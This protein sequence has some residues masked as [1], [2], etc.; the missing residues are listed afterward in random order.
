MAFILADTLCAWHCQ[1]NRDQ[2]GGLS[3]AEWTILQFIIPTKRERSFKT[4]VT[5]SGRY[6]NPMSFFAVSPDKRGH[7]IA[8]ITTYWEEHQ[9]EETHT[10]GGITAKTTNQRTFL[11]LIQ[12]WNECGLFNRLLIGQSAAAEIKHG[13]ELRF[14]VAFTPQVCLSPSLNCSCRWKVSQT[15]RWLISFQLPLK[16]EADL[17]RSLA[18]GEYG[19]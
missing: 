15:Q 11:V 17:P 18:S 9:Q 14:K 16:E 6:A 8:S 10:R 19:C 13:Q 2:F 12:A 4:L 1:G 5:D 7:E 3:S